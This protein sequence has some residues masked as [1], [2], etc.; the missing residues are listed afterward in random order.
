[1]LTACAGGSKLYPNM[2]ELRH[3][4]DVVCS[5]MPRLEH[6]IRRRKLDKNLLP[7]ELTTGPVWT[8]WSCVT[9]RGPSNIIW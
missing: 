6:E 3:Q 8:I 4:L 1:L 2:P 9:V 5:R 7:W